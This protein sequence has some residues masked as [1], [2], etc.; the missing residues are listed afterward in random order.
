MKFSVVIP[1]WNEGAQIGSALKRLR[2]V[3]QSSPLEIILVDGNSTDDTVA[4]ARDWA[5]QVISLPNA[6]RGEQ[7][8][9]GAHKATGELLF[10]L[11][12]DCQPPDSWQQALE[13]FWL[14]ASN[15][16]VAATAFAVDYGSGFSMRLAARWSNSRVSLRGAAF[17][18]HGLC[19]TPEIYKESGGYPHY[20]C[21][22]DMG[23]CERLQKIGRIVLMPERIWPAARRMRRDGPLMTGMRHL[24]L[25]ARFSMG[26]S[27]DELWKTYGGL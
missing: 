6:N 16:K 15:R 22:E 27:P 3:S 8:D 18:E 24:W 10:F 2:Q 12:A 20:A 5:D 23:F 4:Q 11:R 9:A 26:T 21:L 25:R 17:G 13:H 1:T 19:T 7:F 14:S